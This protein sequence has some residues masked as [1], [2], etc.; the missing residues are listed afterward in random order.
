[1]RI[2]Q[3]IDSLDA[4]GAER[5]AVNYANAL[6]NV[7]EFSGLVATRKEGLLLDQIHPSVSYLFLRKKSRLDISAVLRLR[8]Y[9]LK[10]KVTHI[11]AHSTSFF[12]AFLLKTTLPSLKIIR[13]DH[14]GNNEFLE[15]RP[16]SVLKLTAFLFDG[17]ITVNQNLK[18]WSEKVLKAK[19]VIYLPNFAGTEVNV[20]KSTAL[21]GF[22]GKRIIC[23]ANLR[24]Q[25]NHF[26]LLEVAEKLKVSYPEWTFHLVGK[27]FEDEYSNLIKE[28]IRKKELENS[29]F[30]YNSR[31]DI[32]NILNQADIAVL[33]SKSEGFPVALLEY[34]QSKKPVVVTNVGEVPFIIKH[35]YNGLLVANSNPETFCEAIVECIENIDLRFS[36][37]DQ[38]ANTISENFSEKAVIKK[39]LN[40]IHI[41]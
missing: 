2:L 39:Y 31:R 24:P 3:I 13:H 1:M 40:W 36:L 25:K 9:V 41:S 12:L 7:V 14:Y 11:H 10:N 34:G 21:K 16:Y 5:M 22:K 37:G 32:F 27:D 38:L 15:D 6:V 8:S 33:T 23:L 4:G 30:I 29:V 20:E 26:L 35:Y 28:S 18:E 17:A 19:N